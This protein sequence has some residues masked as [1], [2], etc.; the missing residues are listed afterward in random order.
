MC[1]VKMMM[2]VPSA[3]EHDVC[4]SGC[5]VEQGISEA[6]RKVSATLEVEEC[7]WEA[8]GRAARRSGALELIAF[9]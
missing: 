8:W 4:T 2:Q 1:I 7:E 6:T 3:A 5:V 9:L